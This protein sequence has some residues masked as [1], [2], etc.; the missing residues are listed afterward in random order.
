MVGL[1]VKLNFLT[2]DP[3]HSYDLDDLTDDGKILLGLDVDSKK[4]V[5]KKPVR[6][7]VVK[8]KPARKK[9]VKDKPIKNK[10]VKRKAA[11]KRKPKKPIELSPLQND[12][13][14]ALTSLGVKKSTAKTDVKSFFNNKNITT[15][16]NFLQQYMKDKANVKNS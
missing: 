2:F 8:K 4:P 3:N 14:L 12:C 5:N 6:K 15:V 11:K 13:I 16:E 10:V 9:V 7:K 1:G